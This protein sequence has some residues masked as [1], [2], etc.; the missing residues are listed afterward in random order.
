MPV[1]EKLLIAMAGAAGL[2]AAVAILSALAA[3]VLFASAPNWAG[4]KQT[5]L[6][7][8]WVIGVGAGFY[9]GAELLHIGPRKQLE[10]LWSDTALWSDI[11]RFVATIFAEDR[12]RF[13]LLLMPAVIVVELIA[14]WWRVPAWAAWVP[15]LLIA[16]AAARVLLH[17]SVYLPKPGDDDSPLRWTDE[18]TILYL[19]ALAADLIALWLLLSLLTREEV[20][21]SQAPASG[22][23]GGYRSVLP[24]LALTCVGAAVTVIFSGTATDAQL[25]MALGGALAG[26]AVVSMFVPSPRAVRGALGMG[27]VGLF[28]LLISGKF[29]TE[30]TWPHA[31][32][33][34]GAPLLCWLPELPL[35]RRLHPWLRA[36]LAMLLVAIPVAL[37]VIES[38][39]QHE[40]ES[41]PKV[42]G[43]VEDDFGDMYPSSG[44]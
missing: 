25:G 1:R 39:K 37:A 18:Q 3:R 12:D 13:L 33:L 27:V 6:A 23:E 11:D 22:R 41:K 43:E 15:R 35:V 14:A 19:N 38:Q 32:L 16:A 29:F 21:L 40:E 4:L 7:V 9:L 42:P 30:L 8:G 24:A 10:A 34:F 2:A 20:G 28:A 44:K 17:H 31:A 36:I 26:A 5:L